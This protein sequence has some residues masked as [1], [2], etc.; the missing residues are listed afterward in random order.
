MLSFPYVRTY[1]CAYA[2]A[3]GKKE[4]SWWSERGSIIVAV[5]FHTSYYHNTMP[6]SSSWPCRVVLLLD[7]DC[8]YAQC[9]RVRLGLDAD[10]TSLALLQWDSVLAVTYPAR[11]AYNIKRGDSWDA[12]SS[13]SNGN[14]LAL[15]LP[16]LTKQD[17]TTSDAAAKHEE[18]VEEAYAKVYCLSPEEQEKV[19]QLE[20]GVRRYAHE[21]KA[22]LERY[23]IA[24]SRIFGVIT[25]TLEKLLG[26][27]NYVLERASIDEMF[28]DVTKYCWEQ[29]EDVAD[30]F[31]A[32]AK[33]VVVGR[34][35]TSSGPLPDNDEDD[36]NDDTA[37]ECD[38]QI[39]QALERGC[40]VAHEVRKAVYETLGFTLSAGIS[41]SKLVAK[42]GASYGKPNGQAVIM[43]SSIPQV[44]QETEIR[45][46]RNLGGKIGK[47]VQAL[48]PPNEPMTMGSIARLLS[49]PT[50]TEKLGKETGKMVFDAC[51][52]MDEEPVKVTA[53]ALVKSITAFKSFT[54]TSI[55]SR[56]LTE[57]IAL[58]ATDVISRV[59]L[60]ATRNNRYP[61]SCNIQYTCSKEGRQERVTRSVRIPFPRDDGGDVK[62]KLVQ[63]AR[64]AVYAKE[65][66]VSL[67][68]LGLCAVDFQMKMTNGGIASF[69]SKS[70]SAASPAKQQQ[71]SQDSAAR[72]NGTSAEGND[73]TTCE[74]DEDI[75]RKL[76]AQYESNLK[77]ATDV[78][79]VR[80]E[81]S[82]KPLSRN[83]LTGPKND[84]EAD[85]SDLA[86]A[87]KLQA[88]YDR[89]NYVLSTSEKR[90]VTKT[91]SRSTS[92]AKQ[93]SSKKQRI[94]SFFT[95]SA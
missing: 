19:R 90:K 84:D 66:K 87:K 58:L 69:F 76:Q 31:D 83:K 74:N 15:H 5:P 22:C 93:P 23:R 89:E 61:K 25:S 13:K 38:P 68:R 32:V 75:A 73:D 4:K 37:T 21:G 51:R 59:Q 79:V 17:A 20:L 43:P 44:M 10:N 50:L 8:F 36:E 78:P 35:K 57:W 60:D 27:G 6:S 91:K 39:Q 30:T 14:C 48:L 24:S 65:G 33:T 16:I 54:K 55:D 86:L 42:L 53:G 1:E 45:K 62:A 80:K 18:S 47:Q 63:Q 12:V 82:P 26:K 41:T 52:G 49:L 34:D 95:K 70:E 88:Q 7:L 40:L 92:K 67:Y 11:N 85:D 2:R 28:I 46:V 29:N 81:A 3:T 9:E 77:T 94:D 71:V 56:E 72:S 64:D